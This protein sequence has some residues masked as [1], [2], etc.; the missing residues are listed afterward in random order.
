MVRLD[1]R[2]LDCTRFELSGIHSLI[3]DPDGQLWTVAGA[4]LVRFDGQRWQVFP[5]K[6]TNYGLYNLAFDTAGNLWA[7]VGIIRGMGTFRYPGHEP[8]EDSQWEGERVYNPPDEN[9]CDQWFSRGEKFHSPEEC[10]LLADWRERLAYLAPPEGIAPWGE[11]PPIAAE[12]DDRLWILA[13]YLQDEYE[14][15]NAL[16]S[17]DGRNWQVFPWPSYGSASP[18][19][20]VRLVADEARGGVW[21]GTDEG[22]VFSDGQSI[23]KY[24]L[25]PGDTTPAGTTVH[26][27]VV[28]GSDRLWASAD[29]GL[30]LYDEESDTWQPSEIGEWVLISADYQGGLWAASSHYVGHFDGNTWSYYPFHRSWPCSPAVD[31]LADV[32]GGL[33]LSSYHCTLLRFNGEVW[34]EYAIGSRGE[35]L[36]RGLGGAVYAA[37]GSDIKRYDGTTWNRLPSIQV[38]RPTRV[39]AITIGPEGEVWVTLSASPNLIVYRGDEW[40]EFP[41]LAGKEITALLIGS[42]GDVWA[43]YS[44]GLLHYDGETWEHIEREPPFSAINALAE[45]RQGRIWVGGQ[46][47]LSVYDPRGE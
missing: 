1:L 33:W 2:T 46:D 27:L 6:A 35:L 31:I 25:M 28:D 18:Y 41:E 39:T 45:D 11:N 30:F 22:L 29:L 12:T 4:S 23:Q 16:L 34:D 21:V 3:L 32:E 40:E 8:P 37:Q 20:S 44:Q 19:G 7:D 9:D 17:F 36:A 43:G 13:P 5:T 38:P 47:G 24:L 14:R 10:R 42:Q 26:E 15:R